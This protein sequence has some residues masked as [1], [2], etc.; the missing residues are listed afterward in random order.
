M[1]LYIVFFSTQ[2]HDHGHHHGHH[3]KHH[4]EHKHGHEE[5]H[6]NKHNHHHKGYGEHD[7]D[8][9]HDFSDAAYNFDATE[10]REAYSFLGNDGSSTDEQIHVLELQKESVPVKTP[11]TNERLPIVAV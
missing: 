7:E 11:S 9:E 1:I 2:E 5:H 6:D 4:E 10:N 8:E 3:H